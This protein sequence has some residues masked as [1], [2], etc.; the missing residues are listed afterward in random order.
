MLKA[1]FR[2]SIENYNEAVPDASH[3]CHLFRVFNF[4]FDN[5][6]RSR[7]CNMNYCYLCVFI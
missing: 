7:N 6:I 4:R 3:N 5:L 1:L 2:N